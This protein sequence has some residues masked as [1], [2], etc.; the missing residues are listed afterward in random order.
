MPWE[1]HALA[2]SSPAPSY[3][4]APIRLLVQKVTA[5]AGISLMNGGARTQISHVCLR[6][7]VKVPWRRTWQPTPVFLPEKSHGQRSLAG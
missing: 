3:S 5:L 7:A 6:V 1:L 2:N 4:A